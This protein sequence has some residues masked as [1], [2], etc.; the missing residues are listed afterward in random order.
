MIPATVTFFVLSLKRHIILVHTTLCIYR[1]PVLRFI[2]V[3]NNIL[4]EL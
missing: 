1:A 2:D 3:E 4:Q